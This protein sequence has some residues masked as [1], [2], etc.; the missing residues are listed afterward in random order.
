MKSNGCTCHEN[1]IVL[2]RYHGYQDE[3]DRYDVEVNIRTLHAV[4]RSDKG[5]FR[6]NLE[7]FANSPDTFGRVAEGKFMFF[8]KKVLV[9]AQ[10]EY[11]MDTTHWRNMHN[12]SKP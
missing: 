11:L 9:A 3:F 7:R 10:F 6:G 1:D 5:T 2:L 8:L 12:V 4:I